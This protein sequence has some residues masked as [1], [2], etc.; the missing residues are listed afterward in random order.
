MPALPLREPTIGS[1]LAGRYRLLERIGPGGNG[2]VFRAFDEQTSATVAVKFL[3]GRPNRDLESTG[4]YF[5]RAWTASL[6][7]HPHIVQV[8]ETGLSEFGPFITM[9]D[10]RGEHLGRILERHGRLR[11][12]ICFALVEPILLALGAC[13]SIGL[14]HGYVKPDHVIVCQLP[15]R[16]ITVKVLDF[17]A[18]VDLA[19]QGPPLHAMEYLSPEHAHGG[20]IDHRSDLF[21]VC[22]LTYE[23]L[24]NSLPFHGPTFTET[25]YRIINRPCPSL[26]QMGLTGSEALSN[27]LLRG[28]AKDPSCRYSNARELLEALRP[29]MQSDGVSLA[30][31]IP[32]ITMIPM[33]SG[34]ISMTLPAMQRTS[35][36][37]PGP[38]SGAAIRR[39]SRTSLLPVTA[40]VEQPTS[41]YPADADELRA[42]LPA[43]YR[44][45]FRARAVIWQALDVYVRS[46]RPADLREQILRAIGNDDASDLLSGTLQGIVYCKLD[47][48]TQ[49]IE[50]VTTRLFSSH[51]GW[52]R[53]AGRETVDGILSVALTRSIPPSPS[54]LVSLRRICRILSPLFDFGEWQVEPTQDGSGALVHV[55]GVDAVCSGLRLWAF[56][57]VERSLDVSHRGTSLSIVRG[58]ASFTPRLVIDVSMTNRGANDAPKGGT[59]T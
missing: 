53:T 18:M 34:T 7:R 29:L 42:A 26:G 30:E 31:L 43:R 49:Y 39:I 10:L 3:S 45:R 8:H 5:E 35:S 2:A 41:S 20:P 36:L 21:S 25:T 23:L 16:R 17:G 27:V 57:V 56:G 15:D 24:T 55:S 19:R 37:T 47:S 12:D 4:R 40:R 51:P 6:I 14:F 13:H 28:L 32:S 9:E 44:G 58:E 46:R 11:K 38:E 1:V 22:V 54:L 48:I 50:L 59:A 52:C 33:D